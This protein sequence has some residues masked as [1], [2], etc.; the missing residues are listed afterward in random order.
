MTYLSGGLPC[1]YC[2]CWGLSL[3]CSGRERVGQP[4]L[5]YQE[6]DIYL[7]YLLVRVGLVTLIWLGLFGYGCLVIVVGY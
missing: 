2:W 4:R 1:Q 6:A 3:P 5:N 7:F